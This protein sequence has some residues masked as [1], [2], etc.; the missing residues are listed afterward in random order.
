MRFGMRKF[1]SLVAVAMLA[2]C[3]GMSHG[4]IEAALAEAWD[5]NNAE[6]AIQSGVQLPGSEPGALRGVGSTPRSTP[7]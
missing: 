6:M 5:E 7:A 2:A 1:G 3:G 4:D